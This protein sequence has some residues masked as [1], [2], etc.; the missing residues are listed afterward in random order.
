MSDQE[1][2][3]YVVQ[4]KDRKNLS[5]RYKDPITGLLVKRTTGTSKRKD[6][7]RVAHKWEAEIN[8]GRDQRPSKTTWDAFRECC[9]A[10][11]L[12]ALA[13]KTRGS[14][15]SAFNHLERVINP[16]KLSAL[17]SATLS[18]FQAEL[19]K[20]G[21]K[22]TTIAAHLRHLKAAL[23]W[24]V[25]MGLLH[26]KPDIR[27]PKRARG[28]KL[29]RGRPISTEEFERMLA[30]TSRV[31]P[32]DAEAWQRYL[33]GLWLSGLRLEESTVLSWD[34]D[35]PISVDLSGRH[36]QF[37]IY[38]EAEKGCRD[39]LLPMTPDFARWLLQ[40]PD[41]QRVGP[42]F[43]LVNL[44]TGERI[45][46][47]QT[48][49][50]VAAIGRK[51]RVVVNRAKKRV[52]ETVDGKERVVER[53]VVEYASAQDL[54]RSFGTRWAPR[55]KPAT[56]QLLMRH[57]DISTTLNYYVAQD[58]DEV[59]DELWAGFQGQEGTVLGTIGQNGPQ[60]PATDTADKPTITRCDDSGY[61]GGG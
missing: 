9:E 17:T 3:V 5:M 36:P 57:Q 55:V 24:A 60:E 49:W 56:L 50:N 27:M 54:R 11:K 2:K 1:I 21:M 22:E 16:K 10:E 38:A 37:R 59:A 18:R 28:R 58:A 47:K 61:E 13:K 35:A 30:A 34:L 42:V 19:R 8:E 6:A 40:T 31:R 29:M 32:H 33:T 46:P 44:Q 15:T 53:E 52:A 25:S 4:E 20:E 12:S 41:P 7:E 26:Q 45:T 23:N 39:R 43:K 14:F 51:A 48:G